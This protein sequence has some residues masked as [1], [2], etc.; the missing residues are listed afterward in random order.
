MKQHILV[1]GLGL[2]GGSLAAAMKQSDN[3][4]IIGYDLNEESLDYAIKNDLIDEAQLSFE[5]AVQKASVIIFAAPISETIKLMKRLN[6]IELD[7]DVIASDV[8]SVKGSIIEAAN[9]LTN[10]RITFIGG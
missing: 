5:D 6:K 8:S 10:K 2:I 3:N 7:H 1:A 9:E 4:Y